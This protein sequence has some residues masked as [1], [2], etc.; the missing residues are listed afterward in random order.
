MYGSIFLMSLLKVVV[1]A[2]IA[3]FFSLFA[4]SQVS[5]LV[6]TFSFWIAGHFGPEIQFLLSKLSPG[7]SQKFAQAVVSILPNFQYLN[8]RDAF[9]VAG[10]QGFSFMGWA[11]LY[12]VSYAAFFL[13]FGSFL[14]SK[15]EF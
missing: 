3:V 7:F 13:A 4:T 11:F 6:F 15:K 14:F 2:A 5:A 12:S 1:T 8:F 9:S 10:F